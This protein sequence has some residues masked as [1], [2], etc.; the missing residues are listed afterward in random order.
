MAYEDLQGDIGSSSGQ[1]V[2]MATSGN[3]SPL[4]LTQSRVGIGTTEPN[5]AL[6]LVGRSRVQG[7]GY[8]DGGGFW[9]SDQDAPTTNKSFM[10][11]G[12]TDEDWVGFYTAG[13][14]KL[15]IPDSSGYVGIGSTSPSYELDV[16]GTAQASTAVKTP[17]I[18]PVTDGEQAVQVQNANGSSTVLN[19][20][21]TNSRVGIGTTSPIAPL[22]LASVGGT[23]ITL[24]SYSTSGGGIVGF[25][26]SNS[27]TIGV[28]Y[29]TYDGMELGRLGFFGVNSDDNPYFFAGAANIKI[30]QDGSSEECGVPARIQFE[31]SN[32]DGTGP[33]CKMVIKPDG[34]VG[35]GVTNPGE[36]LEVAGGNIKVGSSNQFLIGSVQIKSGANAPN[37]NDG[38]PKGSLYLRT[39]GG[40]NTTLYVKTGSTTWTAK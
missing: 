23:G 18:R 38:A 31:V 13:G 15:V 17:A 40:T 4:A 33:V 11:R 35:I 34:A 36:K 26:T 12:C 29:P 24:Q 39:D 3:T 27:N 5:Y 2:K 32:G 16:A 1:Y 9:L 20:D 19:V 10:G 28:K 21:T 30:I 22:D 37:G 14:W 6:D 25:F 8:N 7:A